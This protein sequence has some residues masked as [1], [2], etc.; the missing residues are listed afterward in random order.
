MPIQQYMRSDIPL[1]IYPLP[2]ILLKTP[3]M[4]THPLNH[5]IESKTSLGFIYRGAIVNICSTSFFKTSCSGLLYDCQRMSDLNG[6]NGCG[7]YGMS[8]NNSTLVV[9]HAL[10]VRTVTVVDVFMNDFS[11]LKFSKLHLKSDIPGSCKRYC[12]QLTQASM[13]LVEAAENCIKLINDNGFIV[14]VGW[15]KRGQITNK[16]LIAARSTNGANG[17]NIM[18]NGQS[19]NQE[20][21]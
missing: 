11:S 3:L 19:N 17:G 14:I 9:Q 8:T 6:S 13:D 20:D 7:C 10:E 1:L 4:K 18:V 15:Y 12:L 2:A 5:E 16:S 21:M